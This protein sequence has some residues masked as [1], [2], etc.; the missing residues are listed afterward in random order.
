[1][2]CAN[3]A[4]HTAANN[5]VT[6][7]NPTT[8]TTTATC[9]TGHDGNF[10]N[11]AIYANGNIY[12]EEQAGGGANLGGSGGGFFLSIPVGGNLA[13][14]ASGYSETAIIGT[15]DGNVV[16]LSDGNLYSETD[17]TRFSA[18]L[19]GAT[20]A[21]PLFDGITDVSPNG[22]GGLVQDNVLGSH[23]LFGTASGHDLDMHTAWTGGTNVT[24]TYLPLNAGSAAAAA[25]DC[26]VAL[27]TG[28]GFGIIQLPDGKLAWSHATAGLDPASHSWI[29]FANL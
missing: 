20:T 29:C 19:T 13:T 15:G 24:P 8:G 16:L 28:G 3:V 27:N 22:G 1:V 25:G 17:Q 18:A 2:L 12:T 11:G 4:A 26:E 9:T 6:E 7:I 5:V 10:S 21:N 14:C 23:W